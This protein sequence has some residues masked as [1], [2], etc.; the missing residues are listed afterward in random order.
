MVDFVYLDETGSDLGPGRRHAELL[1]AA[2]VVDVSRVQAVREHLNS[3][4]E[5]VLGT[6]PRGFEFHG[7]EL[8]SG[9]GPWRDQPPE[10]RMAAYERAL[11]ALVELDL[12]VA[13]SIINKDRLHR[14]YGGA[15]DGNAYRLALQFLLEKVDR[16]PGSFRIVVADESKEQS[17]GAIGMFADLQ[18][19]GVGEVP[20]LPLRSF[21]DSLH[22]VRSH[23]NPGVQL[24]DLTAYVLQRFRGRR[25]SH[26]DA[27]D[28]IQRLHEIV[29]QR[30]RTWRD[31]W[32]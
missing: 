30:S 16:I 3:I 11:Q 21:I 31:S 6:L 12:W 13:Y 8:W 22:F 28:G 4:G 29:R 7:Y 19:L 2:V 24:A 14:R 26:A 15:A 20:G 10:E 18:A 17:S 5:A 1:L 9:S 32:P 25:D 27:I 23:D